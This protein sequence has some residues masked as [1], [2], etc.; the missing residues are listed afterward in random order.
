MMQRDAA[1][2]IVD[3]QNDFCPGGALSV[4]SG[5]RVV[6]PLNRLAEAC[7]AAGIPVIATRDWHPA[8]TRH[9]QDRG[10]IWPRHCV[11]DSPGAAFHPA[12]RL[13]AGT[14]VVSKGTDPGSDGYSAFEAATEDGQSLWQLLEGLGVHHLLI[15]G[16]ATDYCVRAS[17]LEARKLGM[18]VTVLLDAV[19]GVELA[20]GDSQRA[21]EDMDRAGV[22]FQSTR[23]LL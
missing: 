3:V 21:M 4:P 11:Q 19:A 1:L 17:A 5:D 18:T 10:G 7:A 9:F 23:D 16:L 13:P 12:L 14:L 20:A 6:A 8:E 22:G 15:G 2:L